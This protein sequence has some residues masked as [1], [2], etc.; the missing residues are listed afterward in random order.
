M[1]AFRTRFGSYE[2]LVTPFGLANAPSTFQRYVNWIL[3][4]LLDDFVSAYLDDILIFTDGSLSQHHTHVRQVIKRLQAAGLQL[5]LDKCEFDVQ[6]TKYLGFIIKAGKGVSMDPEKTKAIQEWEP[7]TS[8]RG[9]RGFLGFANFYRRF[10]PYFSRL[11]DPLV[12][13]TKKDAKFQWGAAQE[14]SFAALKE[15]FLSDEVLVAFDPERRT[16]VECDSSGRALGAV[17]LQEDDEGTLRTVAYLSR[18]LLT[19]EANYPI[20]DKELLA[21]IYCLKEWDAEL[22]GVREFEVITDHKNL[23][24][25]THKQKLSE[26]HVRWNL[27]LARFPNMKLRYRPGKDNIR[28]DA[29]SRRDQDMLKDE[30][31]EHASS[32]EFTMLVPAYTPDYVLALPV[33]TQETSLVSET[34]PQPPDLLALVREYWVQAAQDDTIYQE[35]LAAVREGRRSLSSTR[36]IAISLSDCTIDQEERLQWRGRVW[37]PDFEP[38]RT[39]VI[40]VAHLSLLTGHPGR[41]ETYRIVAREWYWPHMSDDIRRFVRNCE[42]CRKSTPWRDGKFGYLKPL[43]V[44][45]RT[46]QHLTVDFI[47]G[48]PNSLGNTNLMVVK[49]RLGKGVVLVPMN[50]IETTD[51]AWAFVREVYRHHSLPQSITSDRGPQFASQLW[52]NI[53]KLLNIQRN[54]STAYHPQTDGTTERANSDIEV[55]VRIF[56]NYDQDNWAQLCPLLELMLNSRTNAS[57]GVSPFFLHHGYHNTLFPQKEAILDNREASIA[58]KEIVRTISDAA[59]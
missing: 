50:K 46:W 9:V 44:P 23:E 32:R 18:K 16:V 24:Y 57:T 12:Q 22:R 38:L 45:S 51:V 52:E 7:P 4:D 17:L 42:L 27:E 40:Q 1:I 26:R 3:R 55:V 28:A 15:A 48:L 36:K 21:V 35:V 29:L 25:F 11:V 14:E 58:A 8:V 43:P 53:C 33:Q 20:H 39:G 10:I 19:H 47:T 56:C 49:D 6:R 41:E 31:D 59:N 30:G 34:L 5:E 54:L 2:W 37:V 13:L